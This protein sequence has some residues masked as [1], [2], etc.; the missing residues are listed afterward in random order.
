MLT[1]NLSFSIKI[2]LAYLDIG[3][4]LAGTPGTQKAGYGGLDTDLTVTPKNQISAK[5]KMKCF[6][7]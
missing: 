4:K 5:G 3:N 6:L 2:N 1:L 7:T